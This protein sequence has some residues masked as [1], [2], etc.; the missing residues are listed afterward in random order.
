[1]ILGELSRD[2][3]KEVCRALGLDDGGREKSALV[4][5]LAGNGS[6]S[7]DPP[8]PGCPRDIHSLTGSISPWAGSTTSA[9]T[10]T[11]ASSSG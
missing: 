3:L 1:V 8:S 6:P 7:C 5:R 2:R 10:G 9:P 4:D 11:S